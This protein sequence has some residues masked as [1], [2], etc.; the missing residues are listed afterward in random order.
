MNWSPHTV[1]LLLVLAG[2][3]SKVKIG[4]PDWCKNLRPGKQNTLQK[5]ANLIKQKCMIQET[6]D[7]NVKDELKFGIENEMVEQLM[8][9]PVH[10]KFYWDLGRPSLGREKY[11]VWLCSS[12]LR[13]ETG[14]LIIVA[15]DQALNLRYNLR[16][17]MM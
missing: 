8:R 7:T 13:G 10:G 2:T 15:Q 9:K 11:L 17:I 5:E 16:N 6:A 3:L 1:L 4:L 14:S 12:S